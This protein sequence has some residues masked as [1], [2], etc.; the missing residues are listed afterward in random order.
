MTILPSLASFNA[1]LN[2]PTLVLPT[3]LLSVPDQ[4]GLMTPWQGPMLGGQNG[5]EPF[6]L[7]A[8]TTSRLFTAQT[9]AGDFGPLIINTPKSLSLTTWSRPETIDWTKKP[10]SWAISLGTPGSDIFLH[11]RASDLEIMFARDGND[12]LIG[13]QPIPYYNSY[14]T[15]ITIMFGDYSSVIASTTG[16]LG[17]DRFILGDWQNSYYQDF[18]PSFY[19]FRKFAVVGDFDVSRD[20][21]E[22]YGTAADYVLTPI[23]RF[24]DAYYL[25]QRVDQN[26]DLVAVIAQYT[27]PDPTDLSLSASY[28]DFQGYEPPIVTDNLAGSVYQKGTASYESFNA[29]DVD[30]QG[31]VYIGGLTTG[32]LAGVNSRGTIDGIVLKYDSL[33]EDK[34][35]KQISTESSDAVMAIAADNAG[36]SVYVYIAGKGGD[37]NGIANGFLVRYDTR[38]GREIWQTR[39]DDGLTSIAWSLAVD[40]QDDLLVAGYA[41]ILDEET[42][43]ARDQ[44]FIRKF[45]SSGDQQWIVE[46]ASDDSGSYDEAYGV[47][48]DSEDNV[49]AA[50]WTLGQLGDQAYGSYDGWLV[51]L[52]PN[53]DRQWIRQFGTSEAEF[54]WDLAVDSQGNVYVTGWTFGNFE[55]TATSSYDA[56]L[57]KYSNEGELLWSKQVGTAADDGALGIA[58]DAQDSVYLTGY[59]NGDLGGVNQGEYDMWGLKYDSEGSEVW[60]TQLGTNKTEQAKDIKVDNRGQVYISGLSDGSFGALNAGSFDGFVVKLD[61]RNGAILD[62]Q[63][64]RRSLPSLQNRP[65]VGRPL[66]GS[67]LSETAIAAV[68]NEVARSLAGIGAMAGIFPPSA[69]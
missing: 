8:K 2:L 34:W 63:E 45:D 1:S 19:G 48:L 21:I 23:G 32:S 35:Q 57:I 42:G 50:G 36:D 52:A 3:F 43:E 27:A 54:A 16:V 53:G 11:R 13:S 12:I 40:S 67:L 10:L 26:L 49:F 69:I 17:A 24:S 58:I 61:A 51:K 68:D 22:L 33:G 56:F 41:T 38:T 60:R 55:G 15:R 6:L 29:L 44:S 37:A 25:F 7:E 5:G 39:F 62:F 4:G 20:V 31:N 66:E 14:R 64:Q 9:Q 59:T 65:A 18:Y 30:V 47:A 46:I 28:F